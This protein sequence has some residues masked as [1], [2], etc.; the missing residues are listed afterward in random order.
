MLEL[1]PGGRG[2]LRLRFTRQ[3]LRRLQRA[4][5]VKLAIA[6]TFSTPS[7]RLVRRATV[8]LTR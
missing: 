5:S 4:A 2:V 6:V 1:N 7:G 3:A 8:T